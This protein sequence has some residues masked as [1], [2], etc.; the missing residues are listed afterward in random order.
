MMTCGKCV[1]CKPNN[2]CDGDC[3]CVAK[4]LEV[5]RDDDIRFYGDTNDAPCDAFMAAS[6]SEKEDL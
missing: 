1:H 3:I 4:D 2:V 6:T 5:S